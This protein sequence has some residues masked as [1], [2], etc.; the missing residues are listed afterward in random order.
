MLPYGRRNVN[1]P[2]LV[3]GKVGAGVVVFVRYIDE[4]HISLGAD[5]WGTVFQSAPI[6]VD[7]SSL[8]TLVVSDGALFPKDSPRVKDLDPTE[9]D[10]LRSDL[11]VELNGVVEI[12]RTVDTFASTP[13]EVLAGRTTIGSMTELAFLGRIVSVERL[14]IPRLLMLPA[15]THARMDIRFPLGR[16][17][18][19]E[20]LV[21]VSGGPDS[22]LLSA[23]YADDGDATLSLLGK[24]GAVR[25]SAEVHFDPAHAHEIDIWPSEEKQG[26]TSLTLSCTFDGRQVLGARGLPP[27]GNVAI[28]QS[29][30]N[31]ERFPGVQARFIGPELKLAA[32]SDARWSAPG[33]NWGMDVLVV[34]FPSGKPG[35]H[36]PL[37]TSGVTGAGDLI[38]VIYED[39]HHVRLG[40]DHW[41]GNAL[42]SDPIAVDYLSPHEIWISS[43]PLYPDISPNPTPPG[44]TGVDLARLRS[45]VRVALDGKTVIL[46]ASPAYPSLPSQV[47]V[48]VN[49]IGG[50]TADP[51]FSGI[52]HFA[53]RMNPQAVSW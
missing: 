35:R 32:V 5:V 30:L 44:L 7:Y 33:K 24:G 14:P 27:S 29:G 1:D 13:A 38:Y 19:T 12:N 40:F 8:Q 4:D 22:C 47:T 50:S 9:V 25:R 16:K 2:L 26:A 53:G 52:I 42:I 6:E 45:R 36:E 46:S 49:D 20:P 41:N 31:V 43:G 3:T 17:G 51:A 10:R 37:L 23:T 21:D 28:M 15:A 18:Q 34:T 39:D 11:R 48:G